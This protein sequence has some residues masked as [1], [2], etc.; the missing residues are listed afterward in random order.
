VLVNLSASNITVAKD[1]Y[2]RQLVA[3]Q[4]ARCIAGYL[5]SAAGTGESTTDL[6]WDG[7]GMIYE[8]GSRLAETARFQRDAHLAGGDL[9]LDRLVQD[10]MRQ[11]SFA[12]SRQ[13]FRSELAGFRTI[14]FTAGLP[15]AE[16]LLLERRYER[17]PYVPS[18]PALR[19]VRCAETYNIQV[20]G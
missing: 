12:Q 18:N 3:D 16:T 14:G 7:H 4:S 5:Y 6:A 20:Q 19:D 13:R 9:A 15:T 17:F 1:D 11:G 10:R 2:R 8:N